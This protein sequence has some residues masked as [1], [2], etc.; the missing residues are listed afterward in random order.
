MKTAVPDPLSPSTGAIAYG[1]PLEVVEL[2]LSESANL[3]GQLRCT[4]QVE[5]IKRGEVPDDRAQDGIMNKEV[6]DVRH[7]R[8]YFEE[9]LVQ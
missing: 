6:G 8:S 1:V 4:G 7:F 5:Q 3:G 9:R 2:S